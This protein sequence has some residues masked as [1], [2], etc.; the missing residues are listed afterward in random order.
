MLSFWLFERISKLKNSTSTLF[1][2]GLPVEVGTFNNDS[3]A[4][5]LLGI[6]QL[7]Q[8]ESPKIK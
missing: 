4:A 8:E 5:K 7:K 2:D 1:I 6:P 3:Q